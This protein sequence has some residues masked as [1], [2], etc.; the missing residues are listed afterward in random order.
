V[1]SGIA[2]NALTWRISGQLGN[3][4]DTCQVREITSRLTN[5]VI[6]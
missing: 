5:P 4:A 6:A 2:G 1:T 3:A